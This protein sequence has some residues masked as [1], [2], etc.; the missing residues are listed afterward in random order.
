MAPK[1]LRRLPVKLLQVTQTCPRARKSKQRHLPKLPR[2]WRNSPIRFD[3]QL[4]T[5]TKLTS[6]QAQP[7]ILLSREDK[8]PSKSRKRWHPLAN[9]QRKLST[10]LA[11]SIVLR[12]KRIFWL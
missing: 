2:P 7:L 8:Q 3:K 12:F 10:S 11:S 4:K 9:Q 1:A 6:W 5:Q